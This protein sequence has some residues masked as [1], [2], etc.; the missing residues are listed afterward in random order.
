M[1]FVNLLKKPSETKRVGN[2][3]SPR[4]DS[5]FTPKGMMEDYDKL[6][7]HCIKLSR[8]CTQGISLAINKA[9]IKESHKAIEL[10]LLATLFIP[11]SFSSSLL[12]IN[13]DIL[14]QNVVNFWWFFVLCVPITLVAYSFYL[15]DL[16]FL[17]RY[18]VRFWKGCRGIRRNTKVRRY[19]KD[20]NHIV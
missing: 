16:Q 2:F 3:S 17:K 9:T 7:V 10:T 4:S 8:M 5:T 12:G 19:E 18:W 14:R 13:I 11:L 15:W 20:T 6:Y 1:L